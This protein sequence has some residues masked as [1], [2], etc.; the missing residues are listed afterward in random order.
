M[1]CTGDDKG[2]V[3]FIRDHC[4]LYWLIIFFESHQLVDIVL[5]IGV[6]VEFLFLV[7]S[8]SSEQDKAEK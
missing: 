5:D 1:D 8:S 3:V 6:H 4:L 7:G 2:K